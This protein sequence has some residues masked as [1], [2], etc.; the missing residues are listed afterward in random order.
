MWSSTVGGRAA[1]NND[2]SALQC[3]SDFV[4]IDEPGNATWQQFRF[5]YAVN[6]GN[7][8]TGGNNRAAPIAVNFGGAPMGYQYGANFRDITDGSSNTAPLSEWVKPNQDANWSGYVGKPNAAGGSGFTMYFT[9]NTFVA[10]Q[11]CR[12]CPTL[13]VRG[14]RSYSCTTAAGTCNVQIISARSRHPGG[15]QVLLCDGSTRFINDTITWSAWQMLS[16]SQG[17]D[18]IIGNYSA[19]TV[20]TNLRAWQ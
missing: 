3:P 9:P 4:S 19:P 5:S 12:Q 18:Q 8:D 1:C 16:T 10:D 15:V 14:C 13:P 20:M 2:I 7:T 6:L 17:N 11:R